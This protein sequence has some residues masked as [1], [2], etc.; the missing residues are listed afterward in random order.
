MLFF[1]SRNVIACSRKKTLCYIFE[2]LLRSAEGRH[3]CGNV[4]ETKKAFASHDH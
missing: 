4:A 1:S 3:G 2:P